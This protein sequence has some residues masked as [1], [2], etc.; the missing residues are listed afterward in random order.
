MQLSLPIASTH[1]PSGGGWK[2]RF[3]NQR[4]GAVLPKNVS[5][6]APRPKEAVAG[7]L[8]DAPVP[9]TQ[10]SGLAR[11]AAAAFAALTPAQSIFLRAFWDKPAP[12]P[13]PSPDNPGKHTPTP[14]PTPPPGPIPGESRRDL[15]GSSHLWPSRLKAGRGAGPTRRGAWLPL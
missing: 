7:G 2:R 8:Q 10:A 9:I 14:T 3:I 1:V 4:K 15:T 12:K 5:P 13:D 11:G 6:R